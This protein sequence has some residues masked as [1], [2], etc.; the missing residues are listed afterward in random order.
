[1]R[2]GDAGDGWALFEQLTDETDLETA[3]SSTTRSPW[4]IASVY[5]HAHRGGPAPDGP[6]GAKGSAKPPW[7]RRPRHRERGRRDDG[8]RMR[9]LRDS[10]ASGP[11][12]ENTP[13][14]DP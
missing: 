9:E 2:G 10:R 6:F 1:M 7:S 12:F 14:D 5:R 4:R 3:R 8:N 13:R 11:L